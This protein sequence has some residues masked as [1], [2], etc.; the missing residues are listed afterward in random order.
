MKAVFLDRNTFSATLDLPAPPGVS[1]WQVYDATRGYA[2]IVARAENADIV[3]SNKVV[4]DQAVIAALPR[5]KLVQVC[6]TGVNNVDVQACAA[7][8]IVVQ[9]VAGYSTETV[10]EHT[11]MGILAAMRALKHYHASVEDGR[12][13]ADGRFTLNDVPVLDVAGKTLAIVG[14]GS[15]G[16]RV[17]NIAEAFGMRVLWAEHPGREARDARYTRF[18]DALAAADIVALH[19]PLTQETRHMINAHCIALMTRKPLLVNMARGAVVDGKAVADAVESGALLGYVCDVFA[20]EP[21]AADDPL[22]RIAGHPRVI[23][24]P[25]NAWASEGAQRRLWQLLSERVAAFIAA[26]NGGQA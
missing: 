11:W 2:E 26:A 14:A 20:E 18:A 24:T 13:Q 5:L 21:P 19:C 1:D 25:H 3:L 10:P 23:Y 22:L 4:L 17:G 6:A 15:L 16:Q 9:N 7:R 12:W 8:G